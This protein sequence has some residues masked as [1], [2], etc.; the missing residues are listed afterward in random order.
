MVSEPS[1]DAPGGKLVKVT[2]LDDT[3]IESTDGFG[4]IDCSL[5]IVQWKHQVLLGFNLQRKYWELPG[6]KLEAGETAHDAALRELAEE[7]G[8]EAD[9]VA[10]VARVEFMFGGEANRYV[11]AV[12][13]LSI[14]SAPTL[15]AN[16]EMDR[17]AW[18]NPKGE[19]WK[20]LNP[21]DAEL[22][23]RCLSQP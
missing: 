22:V 13:T 7:T 14:D 3:S 16:D 8:I 10:L 11:A 19:L 17:F 18:W 15:V 2:R 23:R 4:P 1:N 20:G 5:L 9:Q 6:G 21:F 12:F